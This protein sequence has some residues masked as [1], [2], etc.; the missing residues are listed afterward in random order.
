MNENNTEIKA[1]SSIPE[2]LRQYISD[3]TPLEIQERYA[4]LPTIAQLS[5]FGVFDED[6]VVIDTETTGFSFHHDELTQIAAARMA[7]GEIIEWFVTFVNPGK[8]IPEDVAYLTNITDEDVKDALSP[9]E[10]LA[11]LVAFVGDSLV[12]AH[13]VEFDK[14]FTTRHPEGYPLLQNTWIDTLDLSR[15]VL[16]RFR[17]HRLLDLVRAFECPLSTHRADADVEATC[18]IFRILLAGVAAMP[19]SLVCLIADFAPLSDWSTGVVFQEFKR[20][21][22]EQASLD[23]PALFGEVSRE[24]MSVSA[25][26]SGV[27]SQE[28]SLESTGAGGCEGAESPALTKETS[29]VELLSA[30]ATKATQEPPQEIPALRKED[31]QFSLK[32]LRK[33]RLVNVPLLPKK[34]ELPQN[35][36]PDEGFVM[37]TEEEIDAA[38]SEGGLLGLL[39]GDFEERPEQLI[40]S[41]AVREAF[42]HSENL[43]IEAGTGVGKS[44]AYLLPA[45]LLAQKNNISVGVA[46]KTNALLDQLVYHELPKLAAALEE[47]NPGAKTLSFAP[48]KGFTN[49]PC[50]W[51]VERLAKEGPRKREVQ[52]KEYSQAPALAGLLSFIEQTAYDDTSS[53]KIDFRLL[54]RPY[55]TTS[56]Q[57][58][59]RKKCPF[60]GT[61]CFV[62]GSRLQAESS[63]IIVTNHS[64]LFRDL[65]ADGMLL[66]PAKYWIVDEAHN[67][68]NEARSAFSLELDAEGILNI[69]RRISSSEASKNPFVRLERQALS[70]SAGAGSTPIIGLSEKA[71]TIS[72]EY[73]ERAQT[74]S[75]AIKMLLFFDE[76]KQNKN[77]ETVDLWISPDIRTSATFTH[78]K[79]TGQELMESAERLITVCQNLAAYLEDYPN[80]VP[81]QREIAALAFGLKEQIQAGEVIL[82]QAPENYAYAAVLNRKKDKVTDKLQALVLDVGDKMNETLY[83]R[84]NSVVFASATLTIAHTFETFNQSVGLNRTEVSLARFTQ[85]DSSYDFDHAMTIYV[86]EDMPEPT[87]AGYLK[88]LQKFLTELHI[89]QEGSLL[90]LFTNRREMEQCFEAVNPSLKER[91]LRLVCQKWGVSVKGLSDDFMK[92]EHLSL[93]ALK[94]F[95]EGFDAPGATLKGVVIPKLPF[96]KPSDPLYCERAYRDNN[97]WRNYVL[98]G[99]VLE[100]KQ[101]AG[102]LIRKADDSG[103]LVL[104]DKRLL[105]KSYGKVF[106]ES[107]PSRTIKVLPADK[108]IEE[109]LYSTR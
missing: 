59:L 95:W 50:L 10:A 74:F 34:T 22:H 100:T 35:A 5:D 104:A 101:A 96:S 25:A 64:L 94:S 33:E 56:S 66:P 37:P 63:D 8:P 103:I 12:I 68:E 62:F 85:L 108:I 83:A 98:P 80:F 39:Y 93:F 89:A 90:T 32:R 76:G 65:D 14:T 78:V 53:L 28:G 107:M 41:Q 3:G 79:N 72:V 91:D 86:V 84:T 20:T 36:E 42:A 48:L 15:I 75:E 73:A 69:A 31:L 4:S 71:R 44:M 40:M 109:V 23:Q 30:V 1:T 51:R 81:L 49:Y 47:Q 27:I 57:E 26:A 61:Q 105:T 43:V 102:R 45:A 46:T 88:A 19:P 60:Y 13:N 99:A 6:V 9:Q 2:A 29:G 97:A 16:P 21:Y 106:L 17:S 87:Q 7:H 77:Y 58:C 55:F 52:N 38:F 24:T 92:D 54:P 67:A 70:D 18:A 11:Q 82:V